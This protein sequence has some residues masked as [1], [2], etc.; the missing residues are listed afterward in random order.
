[1]NTR[2]LSLGAFLS[3][4]S[5][6]ATL[7]NTNSTYIA[8]ETQDDTIGEVVAQLATTQTVQTPKNIQENQKKDADFEREIT[9]LFQ[10]NTRLKQHIHQL[11][12]RIN[13][14]ENRANTPTPTK[15]KATRPPK[16]PT[17]QT[18]KSPTPTAPHAQTMPDA[19]S[20][21]TLAESTVRDM[22]NPLLQ[23]QQQYRQGQ[24]QQ[25]IY[26]L[27]GADSGGDGSDQARK[28]MYL[29][30]LSHQKLNNCQSVINIGQRLSSRFSGSREAGE[31][32][33]SVGQCQW[34]IQQRDIAKDTWRKLL[35]SYPNSEASKRAKIQ[36]NQ[37]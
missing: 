30:M 23:A 10:E 29:L 24:Y 35:L 20:V 19:P 33:L 3:L 4:L 16:K 21:P 9:R 31:A 27:R 34:N 32:L 2:M 12:H 13:E 36:L 1:M 7:P 26:T 11:Q 18:S 25:V 37:K 28:S 17:P 15:P 8:D 6:C 22:D 14:L 5:A